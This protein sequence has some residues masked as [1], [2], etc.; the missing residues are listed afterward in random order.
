MKKI[1]HPSTFLTVCAYIAVAIAAVL[2]CVAMRTSY[3]ANTNYFSIGIRLPGIAI[4]F[5]VVGAVC[6]IVASCLTPTEQTTGTPFS[7]RLLPSL[8]AAFG[9]LLSAVL[10]MLYGN[11]SVLTIATVLALLLSAVYSVFCGTVN[12]QT[13]PSTVA[14]L[15]FAAVIGCALVNACYYFDTSVEMNAPV[16]VSLQTALLFAMLYYTGEIRCLLG[17]EKPRLYRILAHCTIAACSV[18]ALSVTIAY[19]FGIIDRADYFAG[20][21]LTLGIAITVICR[22]QQTSAA[23]YREQ[24]RRQDT[25]TDRQEETEP[26]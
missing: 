26:K 21:L 23:P 15:G 6:G 24:E 2:R 5:A 20:A 10:F 18:P 8:P 4:L 19:G 25:M 17:R 1:Q 16:K 3:E 9:F 14:L 13:Q 7:A 11:L 22:L 12:R